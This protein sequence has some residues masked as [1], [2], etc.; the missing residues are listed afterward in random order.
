MFACCVFKWAGDYI[1]SV[2]PCFKTTHT[3]S[4]SG[5]TRGWLWRKRFQE[6][7]PEGGN[8]GKGFR[9]SYQRVVMKEKVSGKVLPEGG[10]E[11]KGFRKSV[12]RGWLW[13]KRFQEK[14]Y[15]RVVIKEKWCYERVVI[16]GNVSGVLADVVMK[17]KLLFSIKNG[18]QS[19]VVFSQTFFS[20]EIRFCCIDFD[21]CNIC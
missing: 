21:F 18:L 11:G 9:K 4:K 10:Y 19:G 5:V 6:K 13:K 20:H 3:T 2:E 12:T 1:N 15:Q 8:E 7:L 16:K 14:C 17:G